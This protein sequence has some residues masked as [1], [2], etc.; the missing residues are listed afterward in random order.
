MG[1]NIFQWSSFPAG[2]IS[3]FEIINISPKKAEVLDASYRYLSDL[4]F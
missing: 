1:L 2:L 4:T 3:A